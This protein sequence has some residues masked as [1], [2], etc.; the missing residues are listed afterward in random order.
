MQWYVV[1]GYNELTTRQE[2]WKIRPSIAAMDKGDQENVWY[3]R[4]VPGSLEIIHKYVNDYWRPNFERWEVDATNKRRLKEGYMFPLSN[5]KNMQESKL[6]LDAAYRVNRL[7]RMVRQVMNRSNVRG[8]HAHPHAFRKGVATALLDTGNPLKTVSTFMHHKSVTVTEKF[9]D[10]RRAE[11]I[12]R[13]MIVP[14]G[15]EALRDD[16]QHNKEELEAAESVQEMNEATES[17]TATERERWRQA[18]LYLQATEALYQYKKKNQ[19]MKSLLT[20][21]Q[22]EAFHRLSSEA[23]LPMEE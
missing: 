7:R 19:L 14:L 15:W 8:P 11:D 13:K 18:S 4:T 16:I 2:D 12:L 20:S 22:L 6:Q 17:T 21:E 1:D 5:P 10:K 3:L 23:G 9:Y